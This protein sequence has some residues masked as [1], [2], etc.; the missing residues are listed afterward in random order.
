MGATYQIN[1]IC[2]VGKFQLFYELKARVYLNL[3]GEYCDKNI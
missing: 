1:K 2:K 3:Q